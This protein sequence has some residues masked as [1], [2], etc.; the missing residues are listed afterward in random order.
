MPI[1]GIKLVKIAENGST[2][3]PNPTTMSYNASVVKYN[4]T[5]SRL[6]F[7]F[8]FQFEKNDLAYYNV[9]SAGISKFRS[10][11]IGSRC[12]SYQKVIN[13]GLQ[14]LLL[15]LINM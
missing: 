9:G 2:P 7:D 4:A 8:F 3:A 14:I 5:S 1:F 11:R 12:L 10:C 13:I 15:L 6:R